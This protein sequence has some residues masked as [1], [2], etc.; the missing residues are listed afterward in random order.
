MKKNSIISDSQEL[1][2]HQAVSIIDRGRE[3]I[4]AS[5]YKETTKS[6]YLL[7]KLI[8]E[9]EQQG[10]EKAEYGKNIIQHSSH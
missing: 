5:I 1:L 6:Y 4:V 7:G 8:I 10:K 2:Y 9:D 3:S